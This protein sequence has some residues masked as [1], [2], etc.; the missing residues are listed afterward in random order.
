MELEY[1]EKEEWKGLGKIELKGHGR[2]Q[3][4]TSIVKFFQI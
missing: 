1:S 3:Q 2:G 4:M